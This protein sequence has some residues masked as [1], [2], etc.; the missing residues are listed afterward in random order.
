MSAKPKEMSFGANAVLSALAWFVP[1]LT[2][3]IA[4][5][6]TVRGLGSDAYGLLTL[7]GAVTGYLGLMEMGLGSAIVR[8]LSYYRAL[9]QGRPMIGLL[10]FAVTWFG[11]A[12]VV[13]A[14]LLLVGAHWIAASV[15]KVPPG[16][17]DTAVT[18]LRITAF[19]FL[20]GM[21]VSVGSAVPQCFLRYDISALTSI[22]FG[23][24]GSAG[25]AI[26]VLL[27]FKLVAVVAFAALNDSLS[28]VVFVLIAIRLFRPINRNAGPAWP[29]VRRAVLKFAAV[30]AANRVISVLSTQTS[31]IVVGIASGVAAAAYY[32]I[33]YML[34]S[35]ANN[36]LSAV[37][38]VMFPTASGMNARN[39]EASVKELYLRTS[40]LFFVVN[41]SVAAAMCA[42][43]YP[44]LAFWVSPKYAQEGA[45]ALVVFSITGAVNATTMSASYVNLS[46]AHPVTNLVFSFSNSA[47]QLATVYPLTV[48]WGVTGAA[49]AGLLGA[50]TVP[51]FFWYSHRKTIHVSSLRVWR[52][53]YLPTFAGA[54]LVGVAAYYL[55][56]PRVHSLIAALAA[57]L[58]IMLA[59]MA[60]SG[61]L[62]GIKREDIRSM[63]ALV[64]GIR[65]RRRRPEAHDEPAAPVDQTPSGTT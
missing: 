29:S 6:I 26:L 10:R 31:R 5:P 53:C 39:D 57:F 32:Q 34:A 43:A 64:R 63:I 1:A 24:A 40:R 21:L 27:G 16:M 59:A 36:M 4:V 42:L 37:A 48:R 44:L 41:G 50:A 55:V 14:L 20:A 58:A 51:A 19:G 12:G 62:G 33:P 28:V 65:L 38:Q 25:P 11:G 18:V 56:A 49:V 61:V 15:L 60:L 2:A 30:T 35:R 22:V 8:Y 45:F 13:G 17:T 54:A 23:V 9:N 47:V 52:A 46:A 3:L 7:V